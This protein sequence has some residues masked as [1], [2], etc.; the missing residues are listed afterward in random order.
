MDLQACRFSRFQDGSAVLEATVNGKQVTLI[1]GENTLDHS[2]GDCFQLG[3]GFSPEERAEYSARNDLYN[4]PTMYRLLTQAIDAARL[5]RQDPPED[6]DGL[7][8]C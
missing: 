6:P 8:A 3:E 4:H 7:R 5:Y 1:V 2:Q